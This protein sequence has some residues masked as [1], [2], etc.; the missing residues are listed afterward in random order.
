MKLCDITMFYSES[1]GGVRRYLERKRWWLRRSH[2]EVEH[3]LVVPGEGSSYERHGRH[4]KVTV[5]GLRLP[6]APGYRLP[7][8]YGEINE[9]LAL[10]KPDIIEAASPFTMRRAVSRHLRRHR[11][12]HAFDY[13]HAY[14]PRSYAAALGRPLLF[15]KRPLL[16]LGWKYLR[17][18]YKDSSGVLV[19]SP[20]IRDVLET[21]GIRNTHLAPLGVDL[22]RFVPGSARKPLAKPTILFVGRLTEEKGISV[23][24]ETYR[25]LRQRMDVGMTIAGSGLLKDMIEDMAERDSDL[26]Y[27]DFV[28]NDRMPEVYRRATMLV[29]AAPTETLGLYFLEALACGIPV[30]GLSG[31]GLMDVFPRT[32]A[33]PVPRQNSELLARACQRFLED[34]PPPE[35]CRR[36]AMRFS[37]E[38]RL[39]R[40][41]RLQFH[42]AGLELPSKESR[43]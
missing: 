19:A 17:W 15:L 29:S 2:P 10:E 23:L 3:L 9:I 30:V 11:S 20:V 39:E 7:V 38:Q 27:L 14:F 13:Y 28:P 24:I 18:V 32:V 6:F 41:L 42:L 21:H 35:A 40:I 36:A 1:G 33:I 31:S 43:K 37:W 22:A 25:L 16:T 8:S 4:I 26:T 12:A 5:G 34:P